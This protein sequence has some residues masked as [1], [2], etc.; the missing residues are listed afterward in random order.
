MFRDSYVAI[1]GVDT[2]NH[3][4]NRERTKKLFRLL[5]PELR[6]RVGLLDYNLPFRLGL[7]WSGGVI[8]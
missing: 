3:L 1:S 8:V 2:E 7:E 5:N 4:L 6:Y